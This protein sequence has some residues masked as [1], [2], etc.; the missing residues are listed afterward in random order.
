MS[1]SWG[2]FSD[3]S[4][5]TESVKMCNI[6]VGWFCN[7]LFCCLLVCMTLVCVKKPTRLW[8]AYTRLQ[9]GHTK[10]SLFLKFQK[11]IRNHD[12]TG[13]V[14]IYYIRL[15][16]CLK[17]WSQQIGVYW[18]GCINVFHCFSPPYLIRIQ[19]NLRNRKSHIK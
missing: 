2:K 11:V 6:I 8:R 5:Q 19:S 4:Y 15:L 14:T 7:L 1:I 12:E 17:Y 10:C 3:F 9:N 16:G 18:K 13:I